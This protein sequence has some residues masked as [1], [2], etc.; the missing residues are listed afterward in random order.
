MKCVCVCVFLIHP[1]FDGH[2]LST[3]RPSER[4][5]QWDHFL[6]LQQRPNV[7]QSHSQQ[8]ENSIAAACN[9]RWLAHPLA[10]ALFL[11]LYLFL[12]PSLFLSLTLYTPSSP[13]VFVSLSI[14]PPPLS[15]PA[16]QWRVR[17]A[18]VRCMEAV[19]QEDSETLMLWLMCVLRLTQEAIDWSRRRE[20]W[21]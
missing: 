6:T 15:D 9:Y 8:S 17:G 11:P 7:F 19:G 12:P 3:L 16:S 20:G 14:S 18:G 5:P 1:C 10:L 13:N 2:P 21:G 4:V